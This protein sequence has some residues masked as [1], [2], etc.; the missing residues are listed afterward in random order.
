MTSVKFFFSV[1]VKL[2]GSHTTAVTNHEP[3]TRPLAQSEAVCVVMSSSWL[4]ARE[5]DR[6]L[7]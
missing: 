1:L 6:G 3:L 5:A 7:I 4:R 2:L